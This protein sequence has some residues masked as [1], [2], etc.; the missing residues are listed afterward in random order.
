MS[1]LR[2]LLFLLAGLAG[3]S[4][5]GAEDFTVLV[6]NAENVFDVDGVAVYEDYGDNTYNPESPYTPAHLLTK[7]R[8]IA[9]VLAEVNDGKGPEIILFQEFELDRTPFASAGDPAS[10][11]APWEGTP[12]AEMLGARFDPQV[13]NLPAEVLLW[14]L[15][16]ER[17]M[18][19]YAIAKPDA[20]KSEAVS[21]QNNVVF[22]RFPITAVRQRPLA[23]ARDMLIV[24]LD[25]HGH[26]LIVMNNH[27]KSGASSH[28]TA[29]VRHQNAT[30]V[31]AELEAILLGNPSADVIIAGD[32]N[33]SYNQRAVFPDWG[34]IGLNDVL[35]SQ[36][37][38]RALI[39]DDDVVLYNLWGELPLAERGSEVY[40]GKWGTLMQI[41]LT[42]G[43]YDHQGVRYVDNSF[44]RHAIPG[45]NV[46][47]VWGTPIRWTK[48]GTQGAGF[49]D[50]LPIG[51]R[52]TVVG[53]DDPE[54][55]P[56][57][58]KTDGALPAD[59]PIVDFADLPAGRYPSAAM[60]A[61]LSEEAM[62]SAV[63]RVFD[64][65]GKVGPDG[66]GLLV[67]GVPYGLYLPSPELRSRWKALSEG[68]A[69]RFYGVFGAYR[70]EVQFVVED[71][72]W[73][74]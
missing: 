21:A 74:R 36:V 30:V 27:W 10:L 58:P 39:E 41:L 49:S 20:W 11:L 47:P 70:G 7:L 4:R 50:H 17:G 44:F 42:R 55:F 33:C 37:D 26:E 56:D 62:A 18:G 1:G 73:W 69:V 64:V 8:N 71:V 13:A 43:L 57:L 29:P 63:G 66:R 34:S 45:L 23:S 16:E 25:V 72:S 24:Y 38:E 60:L 15:L 5:L 59:Q 32:L 65:S 31:R 9:R 6:Y 28:R 67:D 48:I 12:V 54:R 3:F 40:R 52:F 14:K 51:A 53:D 19:G 46:E 68:D 35:G 2:S 61:D 22:S